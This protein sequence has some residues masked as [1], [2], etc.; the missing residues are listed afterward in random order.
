MFIQHVMFADELECLTMP[1]GDTI[2]NDI[3]NT[4]LTP[5]TTQQLYEKYAHKGFTI[6]LNNFSTDPHKYD[7]EL[8]Q[9]NELLEGEINIDGETQ[10]NVR[11]KRVVC[12]LLNANNIHYEIF[13]QILHN[14]ENTPAKIIQEFIDLVEDNAQMIACA[15]QVKRA[16]ADYLLK[17]YKKRGLLDLDCAAVFINSFIAITD[18]APRDCIYL[19]LI[20]EKD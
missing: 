5:K 12:Y 2:Y 10:P 17:Q 8:E 11:N 6:S 20:E 16:I 19:D 14:V 15:R 4:K 1:N 18:S 9:L 7:K 13:T 3:I